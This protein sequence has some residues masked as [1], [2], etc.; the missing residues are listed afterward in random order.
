MYRDSTKPFVLTVSIVVTIYNFQAVLLL[1]GG[2]IQ[3]ILFFEQLQLNSMPSQSNQSRRYPLVGYYVH[4][5]HIEQ[6]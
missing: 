3:Y 1:A 2:G 5:S 4:Q 6:V